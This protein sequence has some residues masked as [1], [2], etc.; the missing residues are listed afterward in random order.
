LPMPW[1]PQAGMRAFGSGLFRPAPV[2]LISSRAQGFMTFKV[3]AGSR[4]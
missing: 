2:W 1:L 4:R 3:V